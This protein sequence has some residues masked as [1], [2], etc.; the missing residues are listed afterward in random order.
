MNTQ[1]NRIWGIDQGE[2]IEENDIGGL[3]NMQR[4]EMHTG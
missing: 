3:Q 2:E 1:T 4:K